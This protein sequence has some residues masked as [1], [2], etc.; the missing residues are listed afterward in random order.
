MEDP[1]VSLASSSLV[2]RDLPQWAKVI[3][4]GVMMLALIAILAAVGAGVAEI[5]G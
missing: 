2:D 3:L 4:L 1:M 5:E